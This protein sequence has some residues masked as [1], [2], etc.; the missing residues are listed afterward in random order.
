MAFS[1]KGHCFHNCYLLLQNP[2]E[3]TKDMMLCVPHCPPEKTEAQT[4]KE[5]TQEDACDRDKRGI[6]TFG[7]PA[8]LS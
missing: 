3:K 7:V 5:L 4:D 8:C 1:L 6:Q 2:L